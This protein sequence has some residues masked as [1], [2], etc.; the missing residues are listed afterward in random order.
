MNRDLLHQL[1]HLLRRAWLAIFITF[2]LVFVVH[3][4]LATAEQLR[5]PLRL[6]PGPLLAAAGLQVLF[7]VLSG[8]F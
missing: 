7:W 6:S 8:F 3:Q 2:S 5:A 1:G 4:L